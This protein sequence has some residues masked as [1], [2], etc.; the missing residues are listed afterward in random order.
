M[1]SGEVGFLAEDRR[2]NVAVTRAR[3]HIAVV[4]DSQTIKNHAFLKSL[5]DHITEFGETRTAFEYIQDI[6]PQNYTRDHKDTNVSVSAGSSTSV[7]QVQP[8]SK[9]KEA[10]KKSTNNSKENTA[11]REKNTKPCTQAE[12]EQSKNRYTEIQERVKSFLKDPN[13]N[14]LQFPSSFNSHDRLLVHQIAEEMGLM[15]E[16]TGEGKDRCT[17]VSRPQQ[18]APAEGTSPTEEIEEEKKE[19]PEKR[20]E[21]VEAQNHH[22][23]DLKSLHLERMRREQQKREEN[24][25]QKK[26]NVNLLPTQ[27][28]SLKKTKGWVKK[29]SVGSQKVFMRIHIFHVGQSNVF[30]EVWLSKSQVKCI[31]SFVKLINGQFFNAWLEYMQYLSWL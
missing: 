26:H 25:Q 21:T 5:V 16:S 14:H 6:V 28:Q 29:K 9:K 18:S 19:E 27:T 2:L 15:H 1:I 4:C 20:E 7:K 17:T 8:S 11:N 24:A 3:R 12:M 22:T 31:S 10:H 13:Q 23:L 30:I